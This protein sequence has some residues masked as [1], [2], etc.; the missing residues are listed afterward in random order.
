MSAIPA[1][2]KAFLTKSE[3]QEQEQIEQEGYGGRDYRTE[4]GQLTWLSIMTRPELSLSV[5]QVA[6]YVANPGVQHWHAMDRIWEYL[7][8]SR[9]RELG[10]TLGGVDAQRA[11]LRGFVDADYA[12]CVDTRRS[13]TGWVFKFGGGAVSWRTRRQKSVTLSSTEAE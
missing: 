13:T 11:T 12:R 3:E 8:G 9:P 7:N 5:G 2:P 10:L 4:V 1:H 6:R